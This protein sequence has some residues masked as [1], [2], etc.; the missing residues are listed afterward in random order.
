MAKVPLI[1]DAEWMVMNVVWRKP[2]ITAAQVVDQLARPFGWS[3]AT[4]RTMLNRLVKK[5]ALAFDEQGKRYLYRPAI[6][7]DKCVR[8]E[9]R[10]FLAR[11]FG[12][13]VGPMLVH[14]V[15]QAELSPEEIQQL[16]AL[17]ERKGK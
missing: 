13:A 6:A 10:S 11:V 2:G 1:S 3:P 17:L 5:G 7:R 15:S 8:S 14:F 16:K 9:S 4:I 12:G